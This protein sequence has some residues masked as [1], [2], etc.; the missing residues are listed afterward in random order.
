MDLILLHAADHGL[1]ISLSQGM[2]EQ[3]IAAA[4]QYGTND[5]SLKYVSFIHAEL[6]EQVQAGHV[7]FLPL[8][9]VRDIHNLWV[10][11]VSVI[12][13]VGRILRLIFNFTCSGINEATKRVAP[14]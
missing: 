10:F 12:P 11:P 3:E 7:D 4:L 2:D 9:L 14:M 13:Q 8:G 5:S 6:A 1:L